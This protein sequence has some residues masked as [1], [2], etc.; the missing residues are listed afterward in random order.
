MR[1]PPGLRAPGKKLWRS[2]TAE[3]AL[4]SEPH[5]AQILAKACRVVDALAEL[6]EVAAEAPADPQG[7]DGPAGDLPVHR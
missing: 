1:S 6:D 7:V 5:K 4:E 2:V 3:F